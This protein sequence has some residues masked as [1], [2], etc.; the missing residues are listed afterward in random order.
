MQR[1]N[2]I[3]YVVRKHQPPLAL[4]VV[5]KILKMHSC[6]FSIFLKKLHFLKKLT[7][8]L[9]KEIARLSPLVCR[10]KGLQAKP[11]Q[12]SALYLFVR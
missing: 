9:D 2:Q 12:K 8:C 4:V 6:I 3:R 5:E 7:L 11:Q 1:K 10:A